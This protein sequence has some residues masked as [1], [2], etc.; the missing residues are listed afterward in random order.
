M[1]IGENM[2]NIENS[3]NYQMG[4]IS[5]LKN[6]YQ[7]KINLNVTNY[8]LDECIYCI[9][10]CILQDLISIQQ[11]AKYENDIIKNFYSK[12]KDTRDLHSHFF[13][14]NKTGQPIT[15]NELEIV[16]KEY[17]KM[18]QNKSNVELIYNDNN[19]ISTILT[20]A[21]NEIYNKKNNNNL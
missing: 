7:T 16:I 19:T 5:I 21:F 9:T 17:H 18:I 11:V 4:R 13:N 2:N 20:K 14:S 10:R 15:I 1:I 12:Y 6:L 3:V 8:F